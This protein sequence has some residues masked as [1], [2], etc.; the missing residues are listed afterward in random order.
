MSTNQPA[1]PL[2][3]APEAELL[4]YKLADKVMERVSSRIKRDLVIFGAGVTLLG[5]FGF[6][7]MVTYISDK[8]VREIQSG[9]EKD[10]E[11]LKKRVADSLATLS[12]A[13]A[14]ITKTADAAKARLT[15]LE[16]DYASIEAVNARYTAVRAEVARIEKELRYTNEAVAAAKRTTDTLAK[17][18]VETSAGRPALVEA[19]YNWSGPGETLIGM[20][21]KGTNLGERPG[22][23]R[24]QFVVRSG[25]TD[26]G[27][28]SDVIE[29]DRESII[30]WRND[31]VD[32]VPSSTLQREWT[33]AL[34]RLTGQVPK[35]R[36][37]GLEFQLET[38]N[39]IRLFPHQKF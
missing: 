28:R 29:V 10:S 4:E 3:T 12:I 15:K 5:L 23:V 1:D 18:I 17:A 25:D 2:P 38:A 14:D 36:S 19:S 21:V 24:V 30:V 6:G 16:E 26:P 8:V 33:V 11:A 9:M 32:I 13:A 35:V 22:K 20:V 7:Q 39:G 37:K 34:K 31:L 27:I